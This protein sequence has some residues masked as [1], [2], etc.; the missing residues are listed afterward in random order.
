MLKQDVKSML[1]LIVFSF[2]Q[3]YAILGF[4]NGSHRWGYEK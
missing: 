1:T 4:N 3:D 2:I